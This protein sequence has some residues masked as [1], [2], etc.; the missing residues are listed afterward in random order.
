MGKGVSS[1]ETYLVAETWHRLTFPTPATS[2]VSYSSQFKVLHKVCA[3]LTL[4]GSAAFTEFVCTFVPS[5]R[6]GQ[7]SNL[8]FPHLLI[9][10]GVKKTASQNLTVLLFYC[11]YRFIYTPHSQMVARLPRWLTAKESTCQQE[12]CIRPLGLGRSPGEGNG[13]SLQ[14]PC[15]ENSMDRGAWRATVR[16]AKSQT[17]LSTY[18]CGC[19][20]VQARVK[21]GLINNDN[22]RATTRL[23]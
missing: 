12:M 14:Y 8:M 7:T 16:V 15:L 17:W 5:W 9:F 22:G 19:N 3:G 10:Q 4:G 11:S 13:N 20:C 23:V 18:A 21:E 6:P 1:L 2:H